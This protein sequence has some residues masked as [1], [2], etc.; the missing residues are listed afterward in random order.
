M[1][2]N[3]QE[4]K[5]SEYNGNLFVKTKELEIDES[6]IICLIISEKDT[7]TKNTFNFNDVKVSQVNKKNAINYKDFKVF[8]ADGKYK[9]FTIY[10]EKELDIVMKAFRKFTNNIK[11]LLFDNFLEESP[12]VFNSENYCYVKKELI[13]KTTLRNGHKD[14][15]DEFYSEKEIPSLI[16]KQEVEGCI[17]FK[18][19]ELD[20]GIRKIKLN[21]YTQRTLEYNEMNAPGLI[22]VK[23]KI[24]KLL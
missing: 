15:G 2:I 16:L 4:L 21:M 7:I 13:E 19:L 24:K 8:F 20:L 17:N 12:L 1:K 14:L 6:Q 11:P 5:F 10:E 23:Q 18:I 22:S 9:Q 3:N